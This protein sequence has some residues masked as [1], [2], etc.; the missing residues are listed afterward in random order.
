M[1][2]CFQH[3]VKE[4]FYL[5][6]M[7]QQDT[8]HFWAGAAPKLQDPLGCTAESE[9]SIREGMKVTLRLSRKSEKTREP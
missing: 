6:L 5:F 3:S 2:V 4:M 1:V 7:C 8:T 9:V